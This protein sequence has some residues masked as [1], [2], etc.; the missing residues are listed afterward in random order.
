MPIES[1]EVQSLSHFKRKTG[2]VLAHLK[3]TGNPVVLTVHGKE[4]IVVQD[5]DAY[6]RL[7]QQAQRAE[8]LDFLRRSLAEAEAGRVKPARAVIES[9]GRDL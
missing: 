3:Q 5:A 6:R 9:L 2:D 8:M 4:E 7:A 1:R